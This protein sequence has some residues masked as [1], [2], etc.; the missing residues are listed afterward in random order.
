MSL[1][2]RIV[3]S[4]LAVT[5]LSLALMAPALPAAAQRGD[6]IVLVRDAEIENAIRT[7]VAP[8]LR[9]ANLDAN[10]V[11][12]HLVQDRRINAFVAGGQRIFLN[13]GL[14]MRTE[15]ANQ[16]LGVIAHEAGHIRGAHLVALQEAL[17][18]A[19]AQMILETILAGAAMAASSTNRRPDGYSG[20]GQ[21][22]QNVPGPPG[23][24][25]AVRTLLSYT[26]GQEQQADQAGV[27][28]LE[29]AGMSPRGMLE[30][31]R[32]LQQQERIYVGSG[33]DPYLRTHPMSS[34]RITFLEEAVAR[35]R[36]NT[37]DPPQYRELH[38]RMV[39]KTLGYFE[40]QRAMQKYPQTDNSTAGR[41]G[42][43]MA[44]FRLGQPQA[45]IAMA[46]QL[47]RE[48]PRDPY[49]HEFKG[50]VLRESGQPAAAV[51][52][53]SQAVALLPRD[54]ALRF[55]L[56][57]AQFYARQQV[58]A[59][60]TLEQVVQ[61]EPTNV[62]AWDLLQKAYDA[63]GNTAMRDLAAAE[64]FYLQGH[65][66]RA[67]FKA[68]AA[69]RSLPRGTPAWLRAQDL[70]IAIDNDRNDKSRR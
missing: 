37:S 44:L 36:I 48:N 66:S 35:S 68:E 38:A 43:A 69:S 2:G 49:F 65:R 6:A 41:Y 60:K 10:A 42:R 67:A 22:P 29:R 20:G 55:G 21:N 70:K 18:N 45:A 64:Y 19:T 63:S 33:A 47:I 46:D 61:M 31:M 56:G 50:D 23:V 14:I 8:I 17:R 15:S 58:A 26:R 40:P 34:E 32:M 27:T 5:T 62:A 59:T 9:A 30:V 24:P 25:G 57:Q 12:V 53:Y 28:F 52:A 3:T 4:I 39:A 54:A 16:L 51:G 1:P 7:M 13:T 11:E